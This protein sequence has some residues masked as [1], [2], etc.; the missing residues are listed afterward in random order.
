VLGVLKL[1]GSGLRLD[2]LRVWCERVGVTDLL[3][4]ALV[5]AGMATG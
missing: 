1:Q 2:E 4:R 5:Q 3:D